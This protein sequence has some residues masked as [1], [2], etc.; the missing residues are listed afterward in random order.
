[1]TY[2][3]VPFLTEVHML[4]HT[5]HYHIHIAEYYPLWLLKCDVQLSMHLYFIQKISIHILESPYWD[6]LGIMLLWFL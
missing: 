2:S 1:M 6:L 5:L 3:I 4:V